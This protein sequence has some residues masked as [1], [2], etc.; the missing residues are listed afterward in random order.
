MYS[1]RKE[2]SLA[3]LDAI[4][5][6]VLKEFRLLGL[7]PSDLLRVRQGVL[8]AL[9]KISKKGGALRVER[10][11]RRPFRPLLRYD[12]GEMSPAELVGVC[13]YV[14]PGAL[15]DLLRRRHN[16]TVPLSL[17]LVSV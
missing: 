15:N 13:G 8:Q 6:E 1:L 4:V 14:F 5:V 9:L 16:V 2:R 17:L 3:R 12:D 7:G 10:G 11:I